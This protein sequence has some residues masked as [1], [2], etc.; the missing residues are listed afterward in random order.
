[1]QNKAGISRHKIKKDLGLRKPGMCHVNDSD[2]LEDSNIRV[3]TGR[4]IEWFGDNFSE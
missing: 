1:M 3:D 4:F 2:L